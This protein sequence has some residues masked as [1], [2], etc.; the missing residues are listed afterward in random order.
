MRERVYQGIIG[1]L[2]VVVGVTFYN[3]YE[4][5]TK[6]QDKQLVSVLQ[7]KPKYKAIDI[8]KLYASQRADT[9]A[10]SIKLDTTLQDYRKSMQKTKEM[11]NEHSYDEVVQR[12][13]YTYEPRQTNVSLEQ[14]QTRV[15]ELNSKLTSS[16]N[17]TNLSPSLYSTTTTKNTNV[18]SAGISITKESSTSSTSNQT[19]ATNTSSSNPQ[20]TSNTPIT[21]TD[22]TP[23]TLLTPEDTTQVLAYKDSISEI[24]KVIEQINAN[25]N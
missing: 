19:I 14:I 7:Q 10:E 21:Q 9:R 15:K 23:S 25:L 22:E 1:G 5:D 13:T 24:T 2:I 11:L 4:T 16:K 20:S 18:S 3:V 8:N 12:D 6:V 17:T